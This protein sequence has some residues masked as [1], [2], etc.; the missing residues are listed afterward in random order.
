MPE[1]AAETTSRIRP[2]AKAGTGTAWIASWQL[3]LSG[4]GMS[5]AAILINRSMRNE[6]M[7]SAISEAD[8]VNAFNAAVR[9]MGYTKR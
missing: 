6:A 5:P 3:G 1:A 8:V 2:S 9:R 4:T 7:R